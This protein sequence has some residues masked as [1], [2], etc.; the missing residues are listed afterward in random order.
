MFAVLWQIMLSELQLVSVTGLLTCQKDS[1]AYIV[2]GAFSLV[3]CGKV[4]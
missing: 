4:L 1:R 3:V 2:D